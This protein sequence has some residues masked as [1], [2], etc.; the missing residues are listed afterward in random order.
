MKE[1]MIPMERLPVTAEA[2]I[3]VVG[4]SCTGVFAAIRAARLGAKVVILEKQNRFG[5]CATNGLVCM[6]HSLFDITRE[7]QIIGGLTL[8]TLE[9]LGKRN[10]ASPFRTKQQGI[11]FNSEELTLELDAMVLEQKRIRT[12][13][14]TFFSRPVLNEDGR[15]TGVVAENKSGRF[16]ISAQVF[17]DASGDGLLCRAAGVPMFRPK[18]AQP[19]TACVHIEN[20]RKMKNLELKELIE[21]NRTQ[22]PNLPCG[23]FWGCDIPGSED[24]YMLAGTRVMN[25][26]CMDADEITNAEF[27]SRRQVRALMDLFRDA[28]PEIPV[29]LQALPSE[30]GMRESEHITSI[31]RLKGDEMLADTRYPDTIAVGTYPVDIHGN[32]DDSITFKLLTGVK[33]IFRSNLLL[34]QERW[35]P[36]GEIL[37]YYRIPLSC[38]IPA[39]TKNLIAAGRMLDADAEAFGAVRVMVNLNQ[40]GEAA[41]VAAFCSLNDQKEMAK[42]DAV[43][44]RNLLNKGGSLIPC[45]L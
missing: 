30:I 27:E 13:F 39:G 41:G 26:N 15:I 43:L 14:H 34:K 18:T 12:F 4:G 20:F 10:A 31:G 1:V 23:Y 42:V 29:S 44:V 38:L 9:R 2:D 16:V 45:D 7:K 11:R 33:Q 21:K 8:E 36:E 24:I 32:T 37:P 19:P 28:Y 22:I 35:L 40:C 5:G 25:C 17:V 6:W 3:C